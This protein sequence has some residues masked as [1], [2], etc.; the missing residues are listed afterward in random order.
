MNIKV[1]NDGD[2]CAHVIVTD[3]TGVEAGHLTV[4][5]NQEVS[6]AAND[7]TVGEVTAVAEDAPPEQETPAQDPSADPGAEDAAGGEPIN[8]G[9]ETPQDPPA[10]DG[11]GFPGGAVPPGHGEAPPET[12]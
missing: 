1:L 7:V 10:P 12:V 6:I 8:G 11:G 5:A 9:E 2:G 3:E 4:L